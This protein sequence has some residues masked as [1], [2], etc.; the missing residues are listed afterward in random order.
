M[1]TGPQDYAYA[2]HL[3]LHYSPLE[4]VDVTPLVTASMH[5]ALARAT[6]VG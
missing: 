5:L 4:R 6:R 3:N 1:K 2:T